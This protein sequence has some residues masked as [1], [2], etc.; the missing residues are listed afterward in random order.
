MSVRDEINTIINE[1]NNPDAVVTAAMIVER[2]RDVEKFPSLNKHLW[3]V[4]EA[5]LAAEARLT[6]AHR[7]LITMKVTVAETGEATRML[8]HTPGTPGYRTME[9]V[10]RTPDLAVMKLRQLLD[11][12][13]RARNRARV[14]KAALSESVGAE[15]EEALET[16]ERRVQ[17]AI[18]ERN[19][20]PAEAAA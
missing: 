15:I 20:A 3:Q 10:S 6:R 4:P 8:V 13:A 7:L 9:S 5:D 11:D 14:F 19:S 17:R 1:T 16:A 18:D 12:V 2:A